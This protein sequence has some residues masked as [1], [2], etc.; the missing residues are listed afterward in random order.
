MSAWLATDPQGVISLDSALAR[1]GL[2]DLL[3]HRIHMTVPRTA[4]RRHPELQ[5]HTKR[6]VQDDVTHYEGLPVTTVL[7]TLIDVTAAELADEQVR[8][9]NQEALRRGL[10]ARESL[11]RPTASRGGRIKRLVDEVLRDETQK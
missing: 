11:L 2:S 8:Q 9:A 5:L 3:P 10:V 7:R 1:Y 4:S 6:L